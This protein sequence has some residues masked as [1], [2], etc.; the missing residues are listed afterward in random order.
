MVHL[1]ESCLGNG[2]PGDNPGGAAGLVEI[3]TATG[4][5]RRDFFLHAS[6]TTNNRMAL[7]SAITTLTLLGQK[8]ARV[9]V[10]IVSDSEYLV[11]GVREWAPGW[12]R[13]GWTRKGGP[14]ENL[15][16][17]Q[18]LWGLL[19]SHDAQFT[20]V[21]GHRGHPKNEYANDLAVRAATEQRS[22]PGLVPSEFGTWL[23]ARRSGARFSHSDY[24]PDLAFDALASR[25]AAGESFPIA[26]V[27]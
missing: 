10:L 25:L 21:R 3:R 1:D 20:W 11:K 14:I 22:S 5:E 27:A 16:L 7:A 19:P 4:V 9:R 24:D 23:A 2:R 15:A 12:Q 13:R 26:G 18:E 6:A 8:G 17:W